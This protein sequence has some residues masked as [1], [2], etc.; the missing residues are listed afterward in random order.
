MADAKDH[1]RVAPLGGSGEIGKNLYVIE[2]DDKIVLID[3]GVTFPNADQLGVDSS[4]R[5]SRTSK[6]GRT[7]CW[8]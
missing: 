7:M 2:H 8:P 5:T 6:N 4:C 1:V 3:C